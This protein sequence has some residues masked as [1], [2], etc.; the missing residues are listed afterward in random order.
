MAEEGE[1]K[2]GK[3]RYGPGGRP[4][5]NYEGSRGWQQRI[6]IPT[7][8]AGIIGGGAGILS[9]ILKHHGTSKLAITYA[10]NSAI[11]ASC[12][13]GSRELVRELR[14]AEP[15]D[16]IN[17]VLGGIASG[18][19]L[20]RIQ[21]GRPRAFYYAFLFATVGTGLQ[22]GTFKLQEYLA[23][24]NLESSSPH[25]AGEVESSPSEK[26]WWAWPEWAPIQKLDEEAA[27]KRAQERDIQ[28][29]RTLDKL[30][31]GDSL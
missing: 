25:T 30:K 5:L 2:R 13:C 7:V 23:Q 18:G 31:K 17:S 1:E 28:I 15:E 14:A 4:I 12:F 29:Q 10:V 9:G 26:K 8:A 11:I 19:F 6:Y 3:F 24:K 16:P 22:L 27:A 20:G 21:G